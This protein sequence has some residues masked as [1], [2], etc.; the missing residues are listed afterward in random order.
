MQKII[1]KDLMEGA[2]KLSVEWNNTSFILID[3]RGR[4]SVSVWNSYKWFEPK[5]E[6]IAHV[7]A[8]DGFVLQNEEYK[9]EVDPKELLN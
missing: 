4:M 1:T 2:I 7:N 6:I 5:P 3:E 8:S 9:F